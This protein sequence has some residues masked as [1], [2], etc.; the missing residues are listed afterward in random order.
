MTAQCFYKGKGVVALYAHNED[1]SGLTDD[2]F[3]LYL[4][5]NPD[6]R[7]FYQVPYAT[8]FGPMA[9]RDT[10]EQLEWASKYLKGDD[11][12]G[13]VIETE[14]GEFHRMTWGIANEIND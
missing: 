8:D 11:L 14:D 13:F 12:F 7:K 9:F 4:K 10:I 6:K 1:N 5:E 2:E 3:A